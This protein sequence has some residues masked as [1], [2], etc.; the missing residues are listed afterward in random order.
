MTTFTPARERDEARS[1]MLDDTLGMSVEDIRRCLQATEVAARVAYDR[2]DDG[3]LAEL[4]SRH[5][6]LT[7]ALARREG[8]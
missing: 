7:A 6:R 5:R 3:E 4:R 8:R 1:A 2:R